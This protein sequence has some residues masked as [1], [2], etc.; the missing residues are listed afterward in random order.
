MSKY[1]SIKTAADLVVEVQLRG[2]STAQEDICRAQDIFGSTSVEELVRLANDT[3]MNNEKGEP[4]PKGTWSSTRKATQGTFYMIASS[5][6]NWEDVTRFWNQHTNPERGELLRLRGSC[7]TL[8]QEVLQ[9]AEEAAKE[10]RL[11]LEE[12]YKKLGLK[13]DVEKLQTELHDRDMTIMELKAKLY[14]LLAEQKEA[15]R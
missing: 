5:I 13:E 12:T 2:L 11:R 4:D 14:D 8:E 6:W 9:K 7:K 3:G 15:V 10:H 1:D